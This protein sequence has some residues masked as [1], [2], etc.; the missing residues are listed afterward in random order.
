MRQI[1]KPRIYPVLNPKCKRC[2]RRV[3][4]NLING[5]CQPCRNYLKAKGLMLR[6]K[7]IVHQPNG[8]QLTIKN[9]K[10]ANRVVCFKCKCKVLVTAKVLNKTVKCLNCA[11]LYNITLIS[12]FGRLMARVSIHNPN[13]S[14]PSLT[15]QT[16][17]YCQIA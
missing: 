3:N 5:L 16:I 8:G 13:I 7:T 17:A 9:H 14:F 15:N 1:T 11:Q 2:R 4:H 10:L 6:N 12:G